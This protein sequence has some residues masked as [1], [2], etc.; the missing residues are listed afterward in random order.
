MSDSRDDID[1]IYINI[2][3]VRSAYEYRQYQQNMITRLRYQ[4]IVRNMIPLLNNMAAYG[5]IRLYETQI[6]K[7]GGSINV[8]VCLKGMISK[9]CQT[10][11]A[12]RDLLD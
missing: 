11:D 7:C 4:Q 6:E 10:K 2:A 3:Y 5:Y 1:N 12:Y 9:Y 8:P